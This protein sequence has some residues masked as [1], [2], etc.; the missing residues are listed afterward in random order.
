MCP[1]RQLIA[2][3]GRR[4]RNVKPAHEKFINVVALIALVP[5]VGLLLGGVYSVP[6]IKITNG[7]DPWLSILLGLGLAVTVF[8]TGLMFA[9]PLSHL[10]IVWAV[11]ILLLL[12]AR[13][14]Y[15][16]LDHSLER[17]GMAHAPTLLL[18][19]LAVAATIVRRRYP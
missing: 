5:V 16:S 19:T 10:T 3:F 12:G 11:G 8:G 6:A 15:G 9:V 18:T 1:R 2:M 4:N 17:F 7:R 14:L 13:A